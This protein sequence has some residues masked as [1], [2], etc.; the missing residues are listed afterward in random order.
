[1]KAANRA[2]ARFVV[3]EREKLSTPPLSGTPQW[4]LGSIAGVLVVVLA[5]GVSR[6][7]RA[8]SVVF[9]PTACAGD[10]EG[11]E[12]AGNY[13]DVSSA[14]D[15]ETLTEGNAAVLR[16]GVGRAVACRG[17]AGDEI[18][19]RV[20]FGRLNL[21][22]SF[23]AKPTGTPPLVE[24]KA[25]ENA[26]APAESAD[27]SPIAPPAESAPASEPAPVDPAPAESPVSLLFG[28]HRAH[29]EEPLPHV[30]ASLMFNGIEQFLDV[31]YRIGAESAW[32]SVDNADLQVPVRSPEDIANLEVRVMSLRDGAALPQ[33]FLGGVWLEIAYLPPDAQSPDAEDG[34]ILDAVSDA[35]SDAASAVVDLFTAP[36]PPTIDPTPVIDLQKQEPSPLPVP[37]TKFYFDVAPPQPADEP[38]RAGK[39]V[40][41][42]TG[43]VREDGDRLKLE[44]ECTA[45]YYVVLLFRDPKD[46][47]RDPS[48]AVMNRAEPCTGGRFTVYIGSRDLPEILP[49]GTYYAMI[50]AQDEGKPWVAGN[51]FYP[52]TITKSVTP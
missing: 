45:T 23:R 42:P 22:W 3:K 28:V 16:E 21:L 30:T 34:G 41:R 5:F 4:V 6:D 12:R 7:T 32:V 52:I 46:A 40:V 27:P 24:P 8:T 51:D 13:T 11:S 20:L 15:P 18:P 50:G 14:P 17:F 31:Q 9:H 49:E 25:E 10:W 2:N 39:N 37:A 35:I 36:E 47:V 29:A 19:G 38:G 44:G 43:E 1:M 26:P 33:V 48:R